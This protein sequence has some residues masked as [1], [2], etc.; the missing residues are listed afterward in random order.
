VKLKPGF[1]IGD[2]IPNTANIF[3]DTNPAIVTNTFNTEFVQ[4]LSN[5]SFADSDLVVY[6]NPA[7]SYVQIALNNATQNIRSIVIYDLLGKKVLETNSVTSNEIILNTSSLIK[8][9]YLLEINANS[10]ER[11]VKKLVIQ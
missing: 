9:V 1:A 5:S 4:S 7:S 6:P 10:N 8:G 2:I 3:F 11:L